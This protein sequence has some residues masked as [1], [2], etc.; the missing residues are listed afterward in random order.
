C[1][2]R[3]I[4]DLPSVESALRAKLGA[5]CDLLAR[6]ACERE[7]AAALGTSTLAGES[8][9]AALWAFFSAPGAFRDALTRAAA[10]GG[11][12]DSIGALV[13]A[14]AGARHGAAAIPGQWLAN[15]SGETPSLDEMAHLADVLT[16]R[17]ARPAG[18]QKSTT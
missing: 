11:D 5:V 12:V 8:V 1:G 6:D 13:G 16:L 14:L 18:N 9:P 17:A 15:L 7:A 2:P 4:G 10:L 3:S